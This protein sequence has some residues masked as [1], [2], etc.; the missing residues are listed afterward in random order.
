MA[1]SLLAAV[2]PSVPTE[3]SIWPV[4]ASTEPCNNVAFVVFFNFPPLKFRFDLTD[5]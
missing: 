3:N 2:S 1:E 4:T 5:S